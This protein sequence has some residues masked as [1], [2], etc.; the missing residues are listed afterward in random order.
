MIPAPLSKQ[1]R[2]LGILPA[3]VYAR[4]LSDLELVSLS[5]G[6]GIYEPD[7]HIT[8]LYFPIDCI[9]ARLCELKSGAAFQT[10]VTGNEGMVGI[11]YLLGCEKTHGRAVALSGGSAFRI[12]APLLKKEFESGGELQRLLLRFIEA[13]IVQMEHIA[14]G[15]RHDSIEQRLCYFLLMNL[16]RL[17]GNELFI[18]H[19]QV[20]IFLGTRRESITQAA[21]R[22]A[23]TGAIRYRRGHLR[24]INRQ[25]LENRAGDSY[26]VV[27]REYQYLQQSPSSSVSLR[28]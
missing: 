18:T 13:L 15:A 11:S 20:S 5:P 28:L 7:I 8:H 6:Q 3:P 10:S 21:Q 1:N 9:V 2:I 14:V 19:E 25:E 27:S 12:K 22:L 4:L 23:I 24:V 17:A 16:D 26:A